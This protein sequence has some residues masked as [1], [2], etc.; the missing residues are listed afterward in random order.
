[1]E[2]KDEKR[3]IDLRNEEFHW[4][5]FHRENDEQIFQMVFENTIII[6]SDK[7]LDE[8]FE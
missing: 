3:I 2:N 5:S 4:T 1:M 6:V 8:L 7:Q